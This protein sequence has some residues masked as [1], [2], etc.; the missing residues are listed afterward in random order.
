[1]KQLSRIAATLVGATVL[2]LLADMILQPVPI[3][4]GVSVLGGLLAMWLKSEARALWVA[5]GLAIGGVFG[6]G[7][8]LYVHLAGRSTVPEEGIP[9]HVAADGVRGLMVGALVISV[10]ILVTRI[11]RSRANA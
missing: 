11:V 4:A 10:V 7:I 2:L 9:T 5:A 8:H 1:M 3:P 6:M